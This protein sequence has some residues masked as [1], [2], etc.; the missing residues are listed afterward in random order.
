[1]MHE[2]DNT[3]DILYVSEVEDRITELE[4]SPEIARVHELKKALEKGTSPSKR[5]MSLWSLSL[6]TGN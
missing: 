6:S 2:L 4:E 1:M 5:M 3:Q